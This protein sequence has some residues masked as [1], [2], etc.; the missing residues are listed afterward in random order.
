MNI[1][2]W[3][4]D[5]LGIRETRTR[6][7]QMNANIVTEQ[8][9][10]NRELAAYRAILTDFAARLAAKGIIEVQASEHDPGRKAASDALGQQVIDR[11]VAE[12]K[13]RRH[14]LGEP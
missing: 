3:L 8:I 12:D 6:L 14:T 9:K 4:Q 7:A 11:L 2:S 5:R 13:A 10:T 1:W